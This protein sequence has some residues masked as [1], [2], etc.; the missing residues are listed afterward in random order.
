MGAAFLRLKLK[1]QERSMR[2]LEADPSLA[3]LTRLQ[4]RGRTRGAGLPAGCAGTVPAPLRQRL[5][6]WQAWLSAW[7]VMA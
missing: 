4:V 7:P 6:A 1:D 2:I 5:P 3:G